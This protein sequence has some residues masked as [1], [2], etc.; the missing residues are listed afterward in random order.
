MKVVAGVLGFVA[1]FSLIA[2]YPMAAYAHPPKELKIVYTMTSQ[3]LEVTVTHDSS[4]TGYHYIN[5]IE[6]KKNG[7]SVGVHNY[8]SQP[9]KSE[10][11]YTYDVPAAQGDVLEVTAECKISGSKTVKATVGTQEK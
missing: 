3:K 10:F 8:K 11:T 4:F 9:T 6:I 5:K 7:E 2:L 1:V